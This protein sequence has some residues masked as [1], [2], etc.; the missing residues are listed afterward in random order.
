MRSATPTPSLLLG[1]PL[2][3]P[4]SQASSNISIARNPSLRPVHQAR[5]EDEQIW[6]CYL[7]QTALRTNCSRMTPSHT[8]AM[9]TTDLLPSTGESELQLDIWYEIL[10]TVFMFPQDPVLASHDERLQYLCHQY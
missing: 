8:R 3:I 9:K 2:Q 4:L 5:L 1:D 7:A 6:V 10:P